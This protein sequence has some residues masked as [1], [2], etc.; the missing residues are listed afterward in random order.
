MMLTSTLRAILLTAALS[1][2][3]VIAVARSS[4]LQEPARTEIVAVDNSKA[5]TPAMVRRAIIAGGAH[6]GWKPVADK[7][8]VLTLTAS[9]GAHEV[10]V[11]VLYDAKSFQVKFKSSSNMNEEK[12]GDTVSVH[13]KVNR[14]L[15][16]LNEDIRSSAVTG[17]SQS[18]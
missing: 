12:S 4:A 18:N 5:S 10:T 8:G 14:W 3:T 16:D 9:S 1:C 11:D 13:P 15:A 2:A 6:H 17:V 7:P